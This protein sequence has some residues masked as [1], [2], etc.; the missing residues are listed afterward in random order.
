MNVEEFIDYLSK[1]DQKAIVMVPSVYHG[2]AWEGMS[3]DW[4]SFT[5]DCAYY[6]ESSNNPIRPARLDIGDA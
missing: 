6:T 4:V 1:Q 2:K 3:Y 5:Q